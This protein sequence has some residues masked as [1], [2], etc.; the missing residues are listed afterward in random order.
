MRQEHE[1]D[2]QDMEERF[3]ERLEQVTE[4]F[5]RELTNNR[6]EITV[7]HKKELGN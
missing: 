2:K 1:Q 4:E 3:R 6:E 5:A 7:R